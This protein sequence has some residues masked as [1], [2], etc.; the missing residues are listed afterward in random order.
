MFTI[1]LKM[2]LKKIAR[3]LNENG[4]FSFILEIQFA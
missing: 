2:S 1:N 4:L 3:I